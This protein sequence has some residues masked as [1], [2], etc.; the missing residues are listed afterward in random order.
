MPN[1][2][3]EKYGMSYTP[4]II[5]NCTTFAKMI[6]RNYFDVFFLCSEGAHLI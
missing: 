6:V 2:L 1:S 5:K 4:L 3:A